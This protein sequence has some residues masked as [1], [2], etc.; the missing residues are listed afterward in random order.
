MQTTLQAA[1]V[2][3]NKKDC[4]I[5]YWVK[6]QINQHKNGSVKVITKKS[7]KFCEP[8]AID[9]RKKAFEYAKKINDDC[10]IDGILFK[11]H[12]HS[13]GDLALALHKNCIELIIKIYYQNT[14]HTTKH[15]I[16]DGYPL[17]FSESLIINMQ[18]EY[19]LF[20]QLGY[21]LGVVPTTLKY[22][23]FSH[24]L[25]LNISTTGILNY[26]YCISALE[27]IDL[28]AK[29]ITTNDKKRIILLHTDQMTDSIALLVQKL[30]SAYVVSKISTLG[31]NSTLTLKS[32]KDITY[33]NIWW[34]ELQQTT[35]DPEFIDK[36]EIRYVTDNKYS[37]NFKDIQL[38][39]DFHREKEKVLDELN[40]DLI[41]NKD[42]WLSAE[43]GIE[44]FIEKYC[45][46]WNYDGITTLR[47]I[48]EEALKKWLKS[49]D[50]SE[51]KSYTMNKSTKRFDL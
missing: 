45:D 34:F 40:S 39:I 13:E 48:L 47:S 21:V 20:H 12:I 8:F 29:K 18:M 11:G 23:K 17:K 31:I 7:K 27:S 10:K 35:I 36:V 14:D 46:P 2:T 4:K 15:L 28:K 41:D 43:F 25:I 3:P 49:L 44:N 1:N 42:E 22:G 19:Y 37:E 51:Q 38:N 9:A 24:C 50:P 33:K 30:K 5:V 6:Y 32:L 16:S 26:M